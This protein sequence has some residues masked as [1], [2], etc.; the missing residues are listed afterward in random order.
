MGLFGTMRFVWREQDGVEWRAVV[1]RGYFLGLGFFMEDGGKAVVG[2]A[3]NVA[4]SEKRMWFR[5]VT[6]RLVV[7]NDGTV[8]RGRHESESKIDSR[9]WGYNEEFRLTT[10]CW[11]I[12]CVVK[13][14]TKNFLLWLVA[15][16]D[17]MHRFYRS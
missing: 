6:Y 4:E 5:R 15:H 8:T 17:C 1:I 3:I 9:P 16:D 7:D 2:E 14:K 13:R 12:R 11:N 10:R